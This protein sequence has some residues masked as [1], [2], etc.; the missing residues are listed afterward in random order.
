MQV[1]TR[2]LAVSVLAGFSNGTQES[3]AE[4]SP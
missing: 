1:Q 3:I 4:F 2:H